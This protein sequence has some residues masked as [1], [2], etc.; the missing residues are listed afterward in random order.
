[1]G[2]QSYQSLVN[3]LITLILGTVFLMIVV[4]RFNSV[5]MAVVLQ[6]LFLV[7]LCT[8][9]GWATGIREM[10][11]AALLTLVVKA[12]IIPYVLNKAVN[13]V[14]TNREVEAFLN[15]KMTLMLDVCLIFISYLATGQV[16]GEGSGLI[17]EALPAAIS[18]MLIGLFLMINRKFPIMQ[19]VGLVV[20]ENGIFL[21][22][23]GTTNGMPLVIELGIFMDILVG[24]LIMG[25][26]V[27]RIN[28]SFDTVD[29]RNLRNLRG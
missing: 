11:I 14:S 28:Q 13:R 18:L 16:I 26:L 22:G 29:T 5:I 19:V 12:G 17:H 4:S 6:G 25:V 21:A 3:F 7:A 20:M 9:L 24:V 15:M 1:M 2:M 8:V 27:F 10:Y 23:L